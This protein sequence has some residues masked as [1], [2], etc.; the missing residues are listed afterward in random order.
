MQIGDVV[1]YMADGALKG[2]LGAIEKIDG[3][4]VMLRWLNG[5]P[6]GVVPP[7]LRTWWVHEAMVEP[8]DVVTVLS[9]VEDNPW[10]SR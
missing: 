3:E 9:V 2:R 4:V 10:T 1:R 8:V 5:F 6:R 7:C